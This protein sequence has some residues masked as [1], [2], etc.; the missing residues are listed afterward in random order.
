VEAIQKNR[1]E[2]HGKLKQWAAFA[3]FALCAALALPAS[4][5]HAEV[6]QAEALLKAGNPAAAYTLLEPLEDKYAG[7]PRFDYLLGVAALDSG[8]AD[9]ATL[10]FERVLAVEP[11]FAGARLDMARAYF[12]LGDLSRAKAEFNAV[13]EQDPPPAAR[14]TIARYLQAIDERDKAKKT[15]F[16]GY[17][18]GTLGRDSN[19][20]NSTSQSSITVPALGNLVFTLDPTNVKRADTY[21]LLTAGADVAHEI[22]PNFAIF[23]GGVGR[24][25]ENSSE[26][27]FNYKSIEGRGGFVVGKDSLLFKA[28]LNGEKYYLDNQANRTSQGL[29]GDLRYTVNK[30]N[31]VNL[32]AQQSRYRFDADALKVNDFDLTIAGIGYLHLFSDGRSAVNA[33]IFTGHED[34]RNGRADGNKDLVG[35]RVGG[36]LAVRDNVDLFASLGKQ[37]GRYDTQNTAFQV[38][39]DDNQLDGVVGGVW[40]ITS[41]WSVRPQVLYIRNNSNI[42]IYA[43]KRTDYSVT[44][45]RDFR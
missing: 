45:R 35:V 25:R 14:Q 23:A 10:A 21:G 15:L 39:R 30:A 8:K 19:V 28:T 44:L 29:A 1:I 41:L 12:Q 33:S 22:N 2:R 4:A 13:L 26:D 34:E 18:E 38:T 31:Y 7:I 6:E 9:K 36:Q 3:A 5:Q 32:F 43:Y 16:T 37:H 20:N 27:R 11:N 24:Y 42:S 40:R 17:I